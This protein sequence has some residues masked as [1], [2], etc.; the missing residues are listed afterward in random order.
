MLRVKRYFADSHVC[1]AFW[2]NVVIIDVAADMDVPRMAKVGSAYLA[3]LGRF[4]DGI[5]V[6]IFLRPG[7]PISSSE[8]RAEIAR[9]SKRLGKLL[10]RVAMVVEHEG[11]VAQVLRTVVRG[12]SVVI[13]QTRIQV[14]DDVAGAISV[15]TPVVTASAGAADLEVELREAVAQVRKNFS[16]PGRPSSAIR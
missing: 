13:G 8:A 7:T 9:T 12:I 5:A 15:T 10:L 1:I 4:P 3:L 2:Q 16:S 11:V 14:F 6:M